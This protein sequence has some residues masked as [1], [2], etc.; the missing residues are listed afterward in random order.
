[1]NF[2]S[3]LLLDEMTNESPVSNTSLP[4]TRLNNHFAGSGKSFNI[5]VV[6]ARFLIQFSRGKGNGLSIS[7]NICTFTPEGQ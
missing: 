4:E 6:T 5:S 3:V 1:M 7:T 2:T